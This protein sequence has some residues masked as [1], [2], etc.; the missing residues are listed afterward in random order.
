MRTFLLA[1]SL[2]ALTATGAVAAPAQLPPP[3]KGQTVSF[4]VHEGTS[5]AVTASPDGKFVAIDL[6]GSL[7]IVP[8]KGG[9]ATRITDF[10]NDARQPAW[11]PDGTKLAY[12]AFRDGGYDLWIANPDGSGARKLTTGA[13]DDREPAWSPD[14]RTIAFSSDRRGAGEADYNIWTIDV[15]TGAVKQVT[16]GT[17]EDRMPTWSPDGKSIAY[18]STRGTQSALYA[19]D[20]ATGAER[21][22]REAKARL[23]APSWGPQGQLAYVAQDAAGSR[24]EIDG[25]AVSGS[26][27]VFPFRVSWRGPSPEMWYVSDGV[28]RR[29]SGAKVATVPFTAT[30]EATRPTYARAKRD[31]DSTEPRK[32]L[33]MVRAAISPDGGRIA[34][35]ALGDVW[36]MPASGG[37]PENLT[38][39]AAMDTDVAWSPD[40]T[41]LVF[42]SDRGG[43]LPQ[44]WVRDLASGTDRQLTRMDTQPLGAAWSPD[45]KRIA[46]IDV[47]GRWG[48][49]GVCAVDV[50][51]G[52]VMR[53][54]KT[55]EQP[56]KPSW[57]PDGKYVALALSYRYSRS[58]REGTNQIYMIPADGKGQPFWQV[59]EANASIDT[60]GG[61]GPAW[62]PDG[63][64]MAAIYEGVVKVWPVAADGTPAG[65]L[66]SYTDEISY[67]PTWTADSK[68]ILYQS[69][70][71]LK[72]V[73]LETGAITEI[74]V[75]LTYRLAKPEGRT[76]LHVG[77]LVDA[78]KDATQANKDIVIESNRI[79]AVADHDPALHASGAKVI[80]AGGLTAI[81]GLI[82]H[83]A[84]VQ[85]DFGS[86][87]HKAWLAYGIT[88]VRDPG[89]Q[90]Y[91]GVEEREASEAGVR[92]AP[93][94][95]TNGP[96]LEWQRVYYKMGVAVAGP[97]HLER[98]LERARL[99]KYDVLKSYVR[100][101]DT[102]QRRMV[103]AAHAMGVP[104]TGHEI[105]PAAYTGVDA[106][107]H[108]G[109]TS[110]RGYSPKQAPQGRAYEDVIQLFGQSRRV[111]TPTNFGALPVYLEKHPGFRQD[112][113]LALY[114]AWAQKSVT[115]QDPMAAAL[116][117]A[118]HEGGL[119]AL[120][121]MHDAGTLVA[122]G[123]DT[124]IA[125]N[126]HAELD[127]Y[128]DAGLTPFQALQ[129]ATVNAAKS[130]NLDAGTIEAGKLADI[131]LV[132][133]DPRV[134]I[135]ATFNT[136][137][138]VAN[139]R[140]I[141][142]EE[143]LPK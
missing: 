142:V 27:N 22:L 122:A 71:K 10:F 42:S 127:S 7:W 82:E 80:D 29:R 77:R 11:S 98:E 128:V 113:R 56:G 41:K 64:R 139:G 86:N 35:V 116:R 95:Y 89:N 97:A 19:T 99:L 68:T 119:K 136:R 131:A 74:P 91:D 88:T 132:E 55:L 90:P 140:V 1:G 8:A 58:F 138:V 36:I 102:Y 104:V 12:F 100:M 133:G 111:L 2:L 84:H 18:S 51:T 94:I 121:A 3:G 21:L 134:D 45:G 54:H 32:V 13:F 115:G 61:G 48:T 87:A 106:T 93:R 78:V 49:A 31:W 24:L 52:E 28:I 129:T 81:P 43:G 96:L 26:E 120:K 118:T 125:I 75:N 109:A 76:V 130:V 117:L 47:D 17:G 70:D 103:E 33:G 114:P 92:L 20:L 50:A 44:L 112:P 141:P 72:K 60:R 137:I 40:G 23:D 67:F 59:P 57:S 38:R 37:T 63:T 79:V 65:P 46:F 16:S 53:L 105:F 4:D 66:R 108:M 5:M 123:T 143:L 9:K 14:G 85:K 101:P 39:D 69:A 73:D 30:L 15:A 124:P 126:L 135:A 25:K 107:E 83:H 6:Q 34:F 62:S 110:R